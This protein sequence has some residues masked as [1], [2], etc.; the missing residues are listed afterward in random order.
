MFLICAQLAA[1]FSSRKARGA[2]VLQADGIEHAGRGFPQARRR[3]AD[4]GLFRQ[5]LHHEAAELV[6]VD[7]IF[8][9]DAVTKGSAGGD[10]GV[11][12]FNAGK[13]HTEVRSALGSGGGSGHRDLV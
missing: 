7:D 6:E 1:S 8:E 11:F 12:E 4:H 13:V 10:D 5:T 3:I 9:F 2:D